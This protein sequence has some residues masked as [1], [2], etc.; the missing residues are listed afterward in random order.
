MALYPDIQKRG[1]DEVDRVTGGKR[2]PLLDDRL[3]LPFVEFI[4]LEV[5]R[6]NPVGPLGTCFHTL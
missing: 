6:W 4:V 5:L 3:A 1:Q 2:L